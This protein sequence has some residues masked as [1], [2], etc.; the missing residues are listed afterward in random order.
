MYSKKFYNLLTGCILFC[1]SLLLAGCK[2]QAGLYVTQQETGDAAV[3]SPT[4]QSDTEAEQ[5]NSEEDQSK[6]YIQVAGAV[7]SPGVYI[8]PEGSRIFEAVELAGGVTKLADT[9]TLNQ[10]EIL[11]DGQMIYVYT[12]G[13]VELEAQK[14][15]ETADG[16]I[17]LNTASMEQLMTL[18][19]IG[20]SKAEAI[21]SFREENG[22]FEKIE[23]IMNITGI[24]E[25]VF[26]KIKDRI[27][28]N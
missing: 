4:E 26:S 23:D 3:V 27:K 17:N 28:V 12:I 9:R 22:A 13:E 15:T 19:G 5:N 11:K 21:V 10:A 18:P 20:Q 6:I 8:L 14:A 25:G 7:E 2:N 24:K 1:L 16:R